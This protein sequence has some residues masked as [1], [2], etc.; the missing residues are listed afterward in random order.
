MSLQSLCIRLLQSECLCITLLV[1]ELPNRPCQRYLIGPPP[2]T[3]T[4][5]QALA[6]LDETSSVDGVESELDTSKA[7][8]KMLQ[9][10]EE[11]EDT[12]RSDAESAQ[13][14]QTVER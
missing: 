12:M 9:R 10:I 3:R 14:P 7:M 2:Y 4:Q 11:E 6:L 13:Y 8:G 5:T 1:K